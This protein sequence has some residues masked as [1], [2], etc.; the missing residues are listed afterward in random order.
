MRKYATL[1]MIALLIVGIAGC[2][3]NGSPG[4]TTSPETSQS[5]SSTVTASPPTSSP[6]TTTTST[7][8]VEKKVSPSDLLKNLGSVWSFTYTSKGNLTMIVTV[9]GN[10]TSQTDNVTLEIVEK[11]YIDLKD[12]R[13]WINSTAI[14]SPDGAKTNTSRIVLG[15]TSYL[16]VISGWIKTNDTN[17]ASVV[18][19]YNVVSMA[20]RYLREKPESL[21]TRGNVV[22]LTYAVPDY[23]L[24]TLAKQ[25]FS[26]SP[27]TKIEVSN[28]TLE[29]YFRNGEIAGEK[30][31]FDVETNVGISDPL[32][33][34]VTI[35][36][37]GHWEQVITVT[38]INVKE[39]V[40]APAT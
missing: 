21:E 24:A 1:I 8:R 33:G 34:N 32:L 39:E 36:Q 14:S 28:G 9:S 40:T 16:K 25:Y 26:I 31:S 5:P 10:G 15:N 2:I 20:K 3:G 19:D 4:Q 18:W 12:K 7:Q 38:G 22:V 23:D 35:T 37:R 13:A 27:D 6:A 30:L 11:G 29:F 17:L